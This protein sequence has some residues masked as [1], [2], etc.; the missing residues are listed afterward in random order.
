MQ[1]CLRARNKK[2]VQLCRVSLGG[3]VVAITEP[4]LRLPHNAQR[5][6]LHVKEVMCMNLLK[7]GVQLSWAVL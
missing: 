3:L 1:A 6:D 4:S 2:Q 7:H 5:C